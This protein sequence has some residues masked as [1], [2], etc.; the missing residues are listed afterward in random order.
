M[1]LT[2]TVRTALESLASNK[3]RTLLT[4][5]GVIIGVAAV[6][7]LQSVGAGVATLISDSIKSIGTNVVTIQP[8][9]RI[10]TAR[11]TNA[12]VRALSDPARQPGLARV[13]P[14]LGIKQLTYAGREFVD[15][16]V[17][18]TTP[19]FFVLRNVQMREGKPFT[20]DDIKHQRRVIVLGAFS[21]EALFPDG[22][23]VGS[24][25]LV[26]TVP[27]TVIGVA[28][29]KGGLANDLIDDSMW[30]PLSVA[31][32][33]LYVERSGLTAVTTIFVEVKDAQSISA[34]VK[35]MAR[36]LR[37]QHAL[38]AGEANDFRI[39]NQTGL[40]GT[41]D[42]VVR[43]LTAFL[44]A[45]GAISLVVGGIGIMNIMLVSVTERTREIGL[46]KALGAKRASILL[47]FLVEAL[48]VSILA[49]VIGIA[50]GI[51]TAYAI[52]RA[53]HFLTPQVQAPAIM[54]AFGV[55]VLVGV[56]FG[57]YPAWRASQL[58][59]VI[60]LRRE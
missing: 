16:D 9:D 38:L 53:Q 7:A 36:T 13:V 15:K 33:K 27:F 26:G 42:T 50:A 20:L 6:V 32:E 28:K 35:Q 8:D 5:L 23:A 31:Q 56:V 18:G 12:D 2:E 30:V 58:V 11:L 21:A 49:G 19:D 47:Q 45:I 52:A 34:E 4:M 1:S 54:V 3:L 48:T 29:E 51:V 60:A 40:V 14:E 22:S 43:A 25:V 10:D 59:P 17:N 24:T 39:V 57:L 46:R 55:S 37:Q 44:G 41:L